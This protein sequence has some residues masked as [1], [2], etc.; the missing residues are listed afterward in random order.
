MA[1]QRAGVSPDLIGFHREQHLARAAELAEAVED[2]SDHFLETEIGIETK[3]RFTVPN[4]AER[5]R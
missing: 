2:E 3:P 4:V 5:N 1:F